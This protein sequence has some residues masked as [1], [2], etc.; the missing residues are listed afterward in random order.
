MM[1]HGFQ[2]YEIYEQPRLHLQ[3]FLGCRGRLFRILSRRMFV[4][5]IISPK[6]PL[7]DISA[8]AT[9]LAEIVQTANAGL[10]AVEVVR[11]QRTD[12]L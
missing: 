10:E 5:G 12:R 6:A 3:E 11:P 2:L 9:A 7:N 4:A 8:L 1:K